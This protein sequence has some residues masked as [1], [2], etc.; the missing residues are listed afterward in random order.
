[1]IK[2][3]GPVLMVG[4]ALAALLAYVAWRGAAGT[5]AA[6]VGGAVDLVDGVVGE[7]GNV[8]GGAIGLPRTEPNQCE[9]DKAAGR[10]WD[11]SFS[12]PAGDFLKYVF[13]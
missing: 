1:M 12:C 9:L 2:L 3:S 7:T 13:N 8:L 10:T 4:A 5:G 6:I 11:A